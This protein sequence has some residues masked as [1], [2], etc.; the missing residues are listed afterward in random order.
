MKAFFILHFYKHYLYGYKIKNNFRYIIRFFI[1]ISSLALISCSGLEVQDLDVHQNLEDIM[2]TPGPQMPRKGVPT[3][4][5]NLVTP[6]RLV[7]PSK[8]PWFIDD[9]NFANMDLVINRQIQYF[10]RFHLTG[11]IRFGNHLYERSIL[12]LALRKFQLLYHAYHNCLRQSYRR[13]NNTCIQAFHNT[14]IN[15]FHVYE[16][17]VTPIK[18]GNPTLF[19]GYYTPTIPGSMRRTNRFRYAVYSKPKEYRLRTLTRYQIDFQHLLARHGYELFYTDNLFDI[20]N[21]QIQG[22][23]KVRFE[24]GNRD[25]YLAVD[26]SNGIGWRGNF[27]GPHMIR[28][29][30]IRSG[31]A[32]A[33][34]A[35]L[36]ANPHRQAE[37]YKQSPTYTYFKFSDKPPGSID[38]ALTDGRSIATD[39][40]YYAQ[41]GILAFVQAKKPNHE[42]W[43]RTRQVKMQSFSRFALDQDRGG[44]ITG[45]ARVDFYFGED[46]YAKVAAS[47]LKTQGKIFFLMP[48]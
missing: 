32:A 29:G 46:E 28:R 16:P 5:K 18:R 39:R 23:A 41:K 27:I 20:Y 37:V 12:P 24:D 13:P 6:T 8:V 15:Q 45:K 21:I 4:H 19:T 35:Y 36:N 3:S 42:I 31:S 25:I 33:Q 17:N 40:R 38:I 10:Q 22:A 43:R 7:P 48:K 47:S 11:T 34:R 44:M 9:L 26:G 14:L 30:M 1:I 2:N